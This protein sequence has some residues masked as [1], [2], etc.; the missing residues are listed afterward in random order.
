MADSFHGHETVPGEL[1][2]ILEFVRAER[3]FNATGYC[4]SVLATRVQSRIAA[5]G[6][7]GAAEYLRHLMHTPAELDLL[8]DALTIK[9]SSFFRDPLA[10]EYLN[11]CVLP[12]LLAAKAAAGDRSLRVWSAG[13]A[14]GEE[15]YSV[16]ILL[17]ELLRQDAAGTEVV[18]FATD[19]DEKA[20]ARGRAA[21]YPAAALANVRHSLRETAFTR[22]GDVFRLRPAIAGRVRFSVYDMLDRRSA[23][24][25]ESVFGTFDLILCRNLLIYFQPECQEFICE[26]LHRSLVVGGCLLLGRT[27]VPPGPWAGHLRRV[28][29]CCSLYRKLAAGGSGAGNQ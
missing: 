21:L 3:G 29:D 22:E 26:K 16:A 20:L 27:E 5:T 1:G 23:A 8:I 24:P 4:R 9:V 28:T 6:V 13:C 17:H 7:S 11:E 18:V 25:A 12:V 10:F 2:T 15:P 19:I 14:N